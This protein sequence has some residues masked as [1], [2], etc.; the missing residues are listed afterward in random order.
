MSR[1][2]S[3]SRVTFGNE[4][5]RAFGH[6]RVGGACFGGARAERVDRFA[7]RDQPALRLGQACF[8]APLI[9]EQ[10]RDRRFGFGV[11]RLD[12]RALLLGLPAFQR[13]DVGL[14]AQSL[15]FFTRM[16]GLRLE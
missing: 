9:F 10:P 7:G 15:R 3:S 5:R 1:A 4:R 8:G 12:R 14:A 6:R 16:A 2:I 13:N 11:A